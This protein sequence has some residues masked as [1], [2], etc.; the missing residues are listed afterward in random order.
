MP[1][2]STG[3]E[4]LE[5]NSAYII[6][7]RLIF[8]KRD[9]LHLVLSECA[10]QSHNFTNLNLCDVTSLNNIIGFITDGI[11]KVN[12]PNTKKFKTLHFKLEPS[13][14]PICKE[15]KS[16]NV[17]Q[18]PIIKPFELLECRAKTFSNWT[19]NFSIFTSFNSNSIIIR[20]ETFY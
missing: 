4:S 13:R 5:H 7:S 3:P 6:S 15:S 2:S 12:L 9:F 16:N 11:N 14:E 8:S 17:D 19:Q 18:L 1:L 10:S 20:S